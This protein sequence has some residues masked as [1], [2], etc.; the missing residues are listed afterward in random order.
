MD[1]KNLNL[2]NWFDWIEVI[3]TARYIVNNTAPGDCCYMSADS[4]EAMKALASITSVQ[5]TFMAKAIEIALD[6]EKHL[7]EFKAQMAKEAQETV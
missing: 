1:N 7:A 6:V 4:I 3:A 5:A 2:T